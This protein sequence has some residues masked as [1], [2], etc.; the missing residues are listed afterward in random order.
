[1]KV[2]NMST[3]SLN[4]ISDSIFD[5]E[6]KIYSLSIPFISILSMIA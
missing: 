3:E 4:T 2:V 6:I 1:M 5:E